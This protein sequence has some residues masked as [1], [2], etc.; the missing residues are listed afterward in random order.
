MEHKKIAN[1]DSP[2]TMPTTAEFVIR[3]DV[4]SLHKP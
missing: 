1:Q 3:N 2:G 4:G